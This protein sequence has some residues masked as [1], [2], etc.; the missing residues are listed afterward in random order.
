MPTL[1]DFSNILKEQP[2][3][4]ARQ[5]AVELELYTVGSLS[6]FSHQTNVDT[7]KRFIVFDVKDLGKQLRSMGMLI[8][9]DQIWNRIT[10]NRNAGRRTWV[11]IDE[12]QLLFSNEYAENYFFELWSRARKWGAIPTGIT[13]NVSTLLSSLNA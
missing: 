6:V 8:I 10:S 9:L 3:D 11:Y 13:Q 12:I 5:L 1:K 2:E 7:S 4:E